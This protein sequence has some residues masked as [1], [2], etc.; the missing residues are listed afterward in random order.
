MS[1]AQRKPHSRA[2]PTNQLSNNNDV[3]CKSRYSDDVIYA[4]T[5]ACGFFDRDFNPLPLSVI[6]LNK[7]ELDHQHTRKDR[8]KSSGFRRP[9][10][11]LS[12][13]VLLQN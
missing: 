8:S 6:E 9:S 1:L 10:A 11:A 4:N 12:G 3:G 2:K 13:V 7:S 5:E